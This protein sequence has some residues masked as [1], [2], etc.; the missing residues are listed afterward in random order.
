[1]SN[2]NT[3]ISR[4]QFL[5]QNAESIEGQEQQSDGGKR[6]ASKQGVRQSSLRTV[7]RGQKID[8]NRAE[9]SEKYKEYNLKTKKTCRKGGARFARALLWVCFLDL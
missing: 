7:R 6:W 9:I 1:M 3:L 8:E 2:P 5:T 4:R